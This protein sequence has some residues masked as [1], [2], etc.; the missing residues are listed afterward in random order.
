MQTLKRQAGFIGAGPRRVLGA[1]PFR[2][3]SVPGFLGWYDA[4]RGISQADATERVSGWAPGIG[5]ISSLLQATPTAQPILLPNTGVGYAW[6][7]AVAS[8]TISTTTTSITGNW[9]FTF[10]LAE[11]D[12]TP[13]SNITLL[14]KSSGNDGFK[15]LLLT[16]GVIRVA[17]GDGA[18]VTNFD[19]TVA[20]G[21][22]DFARHTF[23]ATYVDNATLDFTIDSVAL[24]TQVVVN[25]VLTNA[26]VVA[27]LGP[28]N[29]KLYAYS[30]T[31]GGATTY[32][33]KTLSTVA[34][35]AT[36]YPDDSGK[37][38]TINQSGATPAQIVAAGQP[39]LLFNGVAHFIATA[40]FPLNQPTTVMLAGKQVTWTLNGNIFDASQ[41]SSTLLL[42]QNATANRVRLHAGVDST[43]DN[44]W[45]VNTNAVVAA[46]FNGASS[47][48]GIN[49]NA[50]TTSNAG[51]SNASGIVL[52]SATGGASGF[53]NIQAK[54]LA[55]FS[56][57]LDTVMQDKC[58]RYL[59]REYRLSV[60]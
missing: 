32:Y 43:E 15:V 24:G 16:T 46:I 8:N 30:L 23:V 14:D 35:G 55:V 58:I 54:S 28:W 37:T 27:T 26:A 34:E 56:S 39:S 20:N 47:F 42:Y 7:D 21:K 4:R 29:G 60:G 25:K 38:A 44:N 11:D 49:L 31:N 40:A 33:G 18:A 45:G 41:V 19:S 52:G 2:L 9:T 53:A 22:T 59:A 12:Y 5:S 57:A 50:G 10:D 6:N 36:S 51:A 1:R 3:E 13:A 17:V 48:L